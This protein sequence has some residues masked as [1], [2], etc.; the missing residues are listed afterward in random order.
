MDAKEHLLQDDLDMTVMQ[1]DAKGFGIFNNGSRSIT[2]GFD[3]DPN[4]LLNMAGHVLAKAL[5]SAAQGMPSLEPFVEME[6][7]RLCALIVADAQ[8]QAFATLK[9]MTSDEPLPPL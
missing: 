5:F 6:F 4:T 9:R 8:E 3:M 2:F 1:H 7:N